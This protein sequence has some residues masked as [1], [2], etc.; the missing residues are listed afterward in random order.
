M[1][2]STQPR[3]AREVDWARI[4]E[5]GQI[6][7]K[8][9][10]PRAGA[11]VPEF[12]GVGVDGKPRR[13]QST[14]A[15]KWLMFTLGGP[16][17][18]LYQTTE[19]LEFVHEHDPGAPVLLVWHPDQTHKT[20]PIAIQSQ[21]GVECWVAAKVFQQMQIADCPVL[22]RVEEGVVLGGC[23]SLEELSSL[24]LD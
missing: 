4:Q 24:I 14:H 10:W 5:W 15:A 21:S 7:A 9:S 3:G 17:R 6:Q 19:M 1:G 23:E 2:S 12:T 16:E 13:F 20:P 8:D 11:Q 22:F 18:V